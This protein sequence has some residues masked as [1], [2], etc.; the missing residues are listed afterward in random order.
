MGEI[1]QWVCPVMTG[2]LR[3]IKAKKNETRPRLSQRK[4]G[5][6]TVARQRERGRVSHVG[7][8]TASQPGIGVV[9]IIKFL[10]PPYL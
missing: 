10:E 9:Q 8:I 5:I 2:Q 1:N 6:D 7:D 3:I 4:A